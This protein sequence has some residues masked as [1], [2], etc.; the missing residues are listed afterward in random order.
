MRDTTDRI[1]ELIQ[2]KATAKKIK[3]GVFADINNTPDSRILL[4]ENTN[5]PIASAFKIALLMDIE[6]KIHNGHIAV[7]DKLKLHEYHK[8]PGS[9]LLKFHEGSEFSIDFLLTKIFSYS[10]N[11]ATDILG[12]YLGWDS[13][14]KSL[15]QIS[16]LLMPYIMPTKL[17]MLVECNLW[18]EFRNKSVEK[19]IDLWNNADTKLKMEIVLNNYHKLKNL[20]PDEIQT[21]SDNYDS[22]LTIINR[23][24]LV[25]NIGW[26]G[27]PGKW[28]ELIS[29]I[30][31]DDFLDPA[32]LKFIRNYLKLGGS[33]LLWSSINT[34]ELI[35]CGRK[36]GSHEGIRCDMGYAKF[37]NKK[38]ISLVI[39]TQEQT[40]IENKLDEME[41]FI[42]DISRLILNHYELC[43]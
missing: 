21:A 17:M 8:V 28:G 9:V 38:T 5:F 16:P 31:N 29:K 1:L 14:V 43:K 4:N 35:E 18:D 19:Q 7:I 41:N 39:M 40:P 13:I 2:N 26:Q 37:K 32:R 36:G 33:G 27:T 23:K 10:D 22:R 25:Q 3:V 15:P 20:S 42:E 24:L 11:G 12:E 30:A 34:P 6:N